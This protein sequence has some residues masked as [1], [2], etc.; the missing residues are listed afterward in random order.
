[1]DEQ[2]C[3]VP[4]L[5]SVR[6]SGNSGCRAFYSCTDPVVASL[7]RVVFRVLHPD[8]VLYAYGEN[9]TGS[10]KGYGLMKK[11]LIA[12]FFALVPAVT[13]AAGGHSV[14]LDE[15]NIDLSLHQG[16][17]TQVTAA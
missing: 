2:A 12:L 5:R 7:H 16:V 3:T 15:A 11:Q 14:A 17:N 4:V 10:G 1:M 6:D 9:Q 8:A 13:M